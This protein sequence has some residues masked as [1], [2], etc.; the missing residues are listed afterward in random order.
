MII[1]S[2]H[3]QIVDSP[4]DTVAGI[5]VNYTEANVGD[6][7][8]PDPL[9]CNDGQP[10]ENAETWYKK[11]RPEIVALFEQYQ[12]GKSPACPKKIHYKVLERG[13]SAFNGKAKRTQAT[14]YFS[15]N[16]DAPKMDVLFY[17]PS[18]AAEPAPMLLYI[19]FTANSMV[20]DDPGIKPGFIWN[21]EHKK[22]PAGEGRRFERLDVPAVLARGFGVATVYYGDIEP[23]FQ[24]G[25]QYGVRSLFSK[26]NNLPP[27]DDAWGA[28]A[29][30]SWGLSRVL[31][32]FEKDKTV[33]ANRVA[34]MGI[35]RLGKTVLWAGATDPRFALII[36]V[37]SGESGAALSRR[38]YGENVAH[39]ASPARYHYWF[40]PRYQQYANNVNALPVDSHELLALLA[41]RPVLLIT[42]N[43]DKWSDPYGEFLA[44]VAAEPVYRQLGKE[45]LNTE[46]MPPADK[47]ILK[48]IGFYMHDGGH[49]MVPDDWNVILDFLQK[50]L[51]IKD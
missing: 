16:S 18:E 21:R 46:K 13:A 19:A 1:S 28:I 14:I 51:Q 12:F 20:I 22:V 9:T 48:D 47:P 49:G 43:T 36:A 11:R 50:H 41:P 10:V 8:L 5:P 44:A 32:Y 2:A 7:A 34:I 33:D 25:A 27:E 40:A 31:D 42:G 37:C 29:A 45:G 24:E 35:S 4:D 39:I 26:N 15:E 23:D 17:T 6:Y 38:N 30:W 3:S